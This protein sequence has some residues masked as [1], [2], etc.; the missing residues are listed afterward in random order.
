MLLRFNVRRRFRGKKGITR[1]ATTPLDFGLIFTI[2]YDKPSNL[3]AML[4]KD[5][6]DSQIDTIS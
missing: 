3:F 6:E 5:D 1:I 2:L 4:M